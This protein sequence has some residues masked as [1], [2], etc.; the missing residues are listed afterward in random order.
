[1]AN[2]K[3]HQLYKA[4]ARLGNTYRFANL[5]LDKPYTGAEHSFRVAILA[6]TICDEYN[7]RNPSN[8]VNVEE[9][10]RKAILHDLEES[11]LGDIPTPVKN[12]SKAFKE[13]YVALGVEVMKEDVLAGSPNPEYYLKLWVEDK[14]GETGEVIKLADGLEALSTAHYEIRRG[15][16]SLKQAF[17]NLKA[18]MEAPEMKN[19]MEKYTYAKSFFE[20]H[21]VFPP[22]LEKLLLEKPNPE[23]H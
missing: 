12:R 20:K 16:L 10:L 5:K 1:M 8:K 19:L 7:N 21:S 18:A 9:V 14:K 11:L 3:K 17:F 22:S 23:E 4:A 15:N 6:M 13:A 2:E